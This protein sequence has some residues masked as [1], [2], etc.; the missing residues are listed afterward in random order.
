MPTK[1]FEY[2]ACELP[3]FAYG[4]SAELERTIIDSGAGKFVRTDDPQKI[5]ESLIQLLSNKDSLATFSK[6]GR[7]YVKKNMELT[8]LAELI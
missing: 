7:K 1:T 2:F 5:S 6:N 4:N 3:V 8:S